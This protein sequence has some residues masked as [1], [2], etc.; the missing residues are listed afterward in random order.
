MNQ[1]QSDFACALGWL[2]ILI[3]VGIVLVFNL[4]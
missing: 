2:I 3:F 1:C 4:A